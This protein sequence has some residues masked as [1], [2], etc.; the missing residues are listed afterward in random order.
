MATADHA[1]LDDGALVLLFDS[2]LTQAQHDGLWAHVCGDVID[3]FSFAASDQAAAGQGYTWAGA[4]LDWSS[5]SDRRVFLTREL[6]DTTLGALTV[7]EGTGTTAVALSPAFA[8]A[9]TEYAAWVGSGVESV[10]VAA[11]PTDE[12]VTVTFPG[13]RAG[14]A[15]GSAQYDLAPGRNDLEVL[16]TAGS[17][18]QTYT[19]TVV[20]EAEPPAR[21]PMALLTAHLTVG[22]NGTSQG[23]VE[24]DY[25]ALT[26]TDFVVDGATWQIT[27]FKKTADTQ[28]AL[29]FPDAA[30][31]PSAALRERLLLLVDGH[32]LSLADASVEVEHCLGFVIDGPAV[33]RHGLG[34]HRR[35]QGE[36]HRLERDGGAR[37]L[38]LGPRRRDADGVDGRHR[39]PRRPGRRELRLH[40][41]AHGRRR[42]DGGGHGRGDLH[43][44]GGGRGQDGQGPGALHRRRGQ[45]RGADQR[46]GDDPPRDAGRHL[47]GLHGA[48]GP[49]AGLVRDDDGGGCHHRRRVCWRRR[50]PGAQSIRLGR[51]AP[52]G[53]RGPGF[54]Q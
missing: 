16:V 45:R 33:P 49:R 28:V 6:S 23:Y 9:T 20:R 10:T 13:G 35:V 22:D 18:T 25:G 8:S 4:G 7:T 5:V 41:A 48:R 50:Q 15:S 31:R 12:A 21:D 43:A 26:D 39:R 42:R 46:R 27:E 54:T 37:D 29:C 24:G 53:D 2:A 44:G 47:P 36:A 34:R 3:S 32:R 40:L 38:G 14:S 51:Q 11:T 1:S 19:V 52:R 17:S 30:S